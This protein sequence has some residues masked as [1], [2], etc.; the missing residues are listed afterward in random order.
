MA[1][2]DVDA[3][4]RTLQ[5]QAPNPQSPST[6]SD[7]R[8]A[9]LAQGRSKDGKDTTLSSEDSDT[10][11]LL[12]TLYTEI[13]RELRE[14]AH[15]KVLLER[16]Q[17]P[18]LRAALQNRAYFVREQHPARQ[19]L[20]AVAE[21]G[22]VWMAED[23]TDLQLRAKL[24]GAVDHVI[25]NYDGDAAVFDS[26]NRE[27]QE[28]LRAMAHKAKVSERRQVDA[29]QG[30]EKLELAKR[31]A[32]ATVE[33]AVKDRT[34]PKFLGSLLD[35]AWSDVLTLVLLRNGEE[36]NEWQLHVDATRQIIDTCVDN[37]PMPDE[38]ASRIKRALALVGYHEQEAQAITRSLTTAADDGTDTASRTELAMKLKTSTR[39]GSDTRQKSK[40]DAPRMSL[41]PRERACYKHLRTLPFGTWIEFTINY[42]GDRVRRRL[43]W[44]SPTTDHTLFLNQR[45]QRID[46]ATAPRDL[47]HLARLIT[48]GQARVVPTEQ[49]RLV[50]RAWQA[51]LNALR[52]VSARP[53][54]QPA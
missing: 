34:I 15:S 37:A 3:A 1:T 27:L 46:S 49:E 7:I 20:N 28:H 26:A 10:F 40:A 8:Q 42:Q 45:G 13:G 6:V 19:L 31:K 16:L 14:G 29:A 43:A 48:M 54:E 11:E 36:S 44:Y 35:Q 23:D 41:T 12:G 33:N 30:R 32:A 5:A 52:G 47:T 51:A 38:L 21:A 22:A 50:D 2:T 24:Q 4:L 39:L 18:L 53:K 25:T 9:L 17:V